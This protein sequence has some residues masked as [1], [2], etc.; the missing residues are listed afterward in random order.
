MKNRSICSKSQKRPS[1]FL[2]GNHKILF[3]I[4]IKRLSMMKLA[5]T[6]LYK[7]LIFVIL[8]LVAFCFGFWRASKNIV[9][10]QIL[11]ST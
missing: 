8:L 9:C 2:D 7:K 4:I 3:C 11:P 10:I 5:K 6:S 1:I